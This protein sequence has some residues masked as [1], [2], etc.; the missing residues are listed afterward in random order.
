MRCSYRCDILP[1]GFIHDIDARQ[2]VVVLLDL[3]NDPRICI[4]PDFDRLEASI[5]STLIEFVENKIGIDTKD[6][7]KDWQGLLT[8]RIE[9]LSGDRYTEGGNAC[10]DHASFS[11]VKCAANRDLLDLLQP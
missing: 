10:S 3:C 2:F 9:Y 11:V 7:A 4:A 6:V 5:E 8:K 1:F